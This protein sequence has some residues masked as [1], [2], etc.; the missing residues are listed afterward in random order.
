MTSLSSG[1]LRPLYLRKTSFLRSLFAIA[2]GTILLAA[3]SHIQIP[4]IPVPMTMQ[5]LAVTLIGAIYGWRLGAATV[6]AWLLEGAIGLPVFAGGASG[7][8]HL[9]GKTGGYLFSFPL[10]AMVVGALA[11]RG[12]DGSHFERAFSAMVIGNA[13][14]LVIGAAWLAAFIGWEKA[15]TFGVTPFVFGGLLKSALGAGLLKVIMPGD[16]LRR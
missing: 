5:T 13:L 7:V 2:F 14:C 4:M 11:E 6:L 15:M 3:S 1:L 12:W 16:K 9:L 8:P 10:V